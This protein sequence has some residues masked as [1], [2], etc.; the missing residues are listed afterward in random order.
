MGFDGNLPW[1]DHRSSNNSMEHGTLIP[2]ISCAVCH[3]ECWQLSN[4]LPSNNG[5]TWLRWTVLIST[6]AT[7]NAKKPWTSWPY[8]WPANPTK[9]RR[10]L[11]ASW[12]SWAD[13]FAKGEATPQENSSADRN[14]PVL[15]V[16]PQKNRFLPHYKWGR[17]H[18][19]PKLFIFW[20]SATVSVSAILIAFSCS[21]NLCAI[22]R[23]VAR[24]T[25]TNPSTGTVVSQALTNGFN[26]NG[27]QCWL[28]KTKNISI[29]ILPHV[30]NFKTLTHASSTLFF[31][32]NLESFWKVQLFRAQMGQVSTMALATFGETSGQC[33][34]DP[35]GAS[36]GFKEGQA[37]ANRRRLAGTFLH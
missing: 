27:H 23:L 33:R 22:S 25:S 6:A 7:T 28:K 12:T 26:H 2:F 32:K 4:L 29:Y 37:A 17:P 19:G 13:S 14:W 3:S 11:W 1:K 18:A 20:V 36:C 35:L 16:Y 21:C 5:K 9:W 31:W 10:K 34:V 8:R 15:T 24:V 30:S